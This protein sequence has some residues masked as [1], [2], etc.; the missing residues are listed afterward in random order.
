L[1]PLAPSWS[2]ASIDGRIQ[3]WDIESSQSLINIV[4]AK[5]V[6]VS[7]DLFGQ[8]SAGYI[9]VEGRMFIFRAYWAAPN[10][11]SGFVTYDVSADSLLDW[12]V[13]FLDKGPDDLYFLPI[14][15]IVSRTK[16]LILRKEE[17]EEGTP[18]FSR[19]GW[20]L[21][22]EEG[23]IA[24]TEEKIVEWEKPPWDAQSLSKVRL[25]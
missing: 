24:G 15:Q 6:L 22:G 23:N 8:V 11:Y 16:G 19:I 2:W 1:I 18:T 12:G 21:V 20:A 13:I 5:T 7:E 10:F 3:T 4:D 25:I 9:E 14:M 17:A